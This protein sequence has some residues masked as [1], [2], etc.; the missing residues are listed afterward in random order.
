MLLELLLPL[1]VNLWFCPP[2]L[3]L[4]FPVGFPCLFILM[5]GALQFRYLST[6]LFTCLRAPAFRRGMWAVLF[7]YR[8]FFLKRP[9]NFNLNKYTLSQA[10][11][12]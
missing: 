7:T 9:S 10:G 8:A 2:G 4:H 5:S 1:W 6:I 11:S 12:R 3:L